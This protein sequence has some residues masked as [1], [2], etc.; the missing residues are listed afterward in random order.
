MKK[1]KKGKILVCMA[2]AGVVVGTTVG[3]TSAFAKEQ[4]I[5]KVLVTKDGYEFT[6]S[7]FGA[8]ITGYNFNPDNSLF[9][10]IERDGR[11]Y[12]IS[13]V[14]ATYDE[15]K[16][17]CEENGGELIS[18]DSQAEKDALTRVATTQ[19]LPVIIEGITFYGYGRDTVA[20]SN[21]KDFFTLFGDESTL[22]KLESDKKV[23]LY[24]YYNTALTYANDDA[25]LSYSATNKFQK[26][27]GNQWWESSDLKLVTNYDV[28]SYFVCEWDSKPQN[29]HVFSTD[30]VIPQR[31]NGMV[32][33]TVDK[34]AFPKF[35]GYRAYM[36][37]LTIS[38]KITNIEEGT[39]SGATNMK[40][41]SFPCTLQTIDAYAFE[42]N[43]LTEL[44]LPSYLYK[45]GNYAFHVSK[46]NSVT[47]N[48]RLNSIGES[49][50]E[51][52]GL[53]NS[54]TI[55]RNLKTIGKNAFRFC[56]MT[57]VTIPGTVSTIG[58]GAF[59]KTELKTVTI[60][61]GVKKIENDAF[62][63][64]NLTEINLPSGLTHLGSGV[65]ECAKVDTLTIPKT[66]KTFGTGKV[67]MY[68]RGPKTIAFQSGTYSI[69][70]EALKNWTTK[71]VEVPNTV[72]YIGD[73]AF[74]NPFIKTAVIPTTIKE[75]N[76]NKLF[77][78]STVT[79]EYG[80]KVITV[81]PQ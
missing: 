13:T 39:F 7:N 53:K 15:A 30:F 5:S 45:I 47:F 49:A 61:K 23:S 57:D 62:R 11:Y 20:E 43:G 51:Y 68:G 34:D 60:N 33:R 6:P 28:S 27:Y 4:K 21:M 31:V 78:T 38:A 52:A 35:D 1:N 67:D 26:R 75:E 55:N 32:V 59:C 50:F 41:V 81:T 63:F 80:D 36:D 40:S 56:K 54:V 37:S 66:V 70:S 14:K 25:A 18:V 48:N 29:M 73:D 71:R 65:V 64:T 76:L 8:R 79:V 10:G 72:R 19:Q 16:K 69:P 58:E 46:L 2:L 3:A 77:G 44:N 74:D 17:I 9:Y 22:T 42:N 24:K 12:G